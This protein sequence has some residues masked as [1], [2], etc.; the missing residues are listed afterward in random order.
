M[1]EV[2]NGKAMENNPQDGERESEIR[3]DVESEY[4]C[5]GAS[6]GR[7]VVETLLAKNGVRL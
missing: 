2:A 1:R 6:K 3:A 7:T 5:V 4:R